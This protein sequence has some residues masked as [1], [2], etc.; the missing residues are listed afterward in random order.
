MSDDTNGPANCAEA[1]CETT[2]PRISEAMLASC[3]VMP[4][5]A[6]R[7]IPATTTMA[8]AAS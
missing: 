8:I 5:Q 2:K 4:I 6:P 1:W 7:I 3:Q